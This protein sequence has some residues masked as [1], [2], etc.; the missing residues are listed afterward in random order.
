VGVAGGPG[1]RPSRCRAAGG[2]ALGLVAATGFTAELWEYALDSGSFADARTAA[3]A[4]AALRRLSLENGMSH[5]ALAAK[6]SI[7]L[8]SV[9]RLP[10]APG[11][12]QA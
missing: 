7:S 4:G 5:R 6:Y 9:Q 12:P 1:V 8:S 2:G 3:E 10:K 11:G